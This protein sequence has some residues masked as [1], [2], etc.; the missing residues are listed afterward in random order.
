MKLVSLFSGGKDSTIA[1]YKAIKADNDVKILLSFVPD[2]E[3]YMF[4]YPNI[5]FAKISAEAMNIP[6]IMKESGK[7]KEKE[8]DDLKTEISALKND[9]ELDG[10]CVGAVSSNYQYSRVKKVSDELNLEVYAPYWQKSH[11]KLIREAINLNFKILIV[12]VYADGFDESWLG[13]ELDL[14]ALDDLKKLEEKFHINIGGEGGEYETFVLDCPLFR[15]RIVIDEAEKIWGK[16]RGELLIKKV[17]L[18]DKF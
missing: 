13:R 5:K 17:R 8:I 7:D 6:I 1:T 3:S 10:V 4:H 14:K 15:K 9:C 11:G 16:V 2:E 12:G 18:A